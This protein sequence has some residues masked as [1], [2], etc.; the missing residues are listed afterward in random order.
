M[1]RAP[2]LVMAT[3]SESE[4]KILGEKACPISKY[5]LSLHQSSGSHGCGCIVILSRRT[6]GDEN[7]L[8]GAN[9]VRLLKWDKDK[10]FC[11]KEKLHHFETNNNYDSE[12][13]NDNCET[14]RIIQPQSR[15]PPKLRL[16]VRLETEQTP[17]SGQ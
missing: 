17:N 3:K 4:T 8:S 11:R 12:A 1:Q 14:G 7:R 6:T 10:R 2:F 9:Q 13:E 15:Q 5:F 16:P